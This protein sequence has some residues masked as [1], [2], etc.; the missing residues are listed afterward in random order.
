VNSPDAPI[1]IIGAG[2]VGLV[3]AVGMTEAGHQVELVEADPDR[4]ATLRTG[5]IP[6]F[7]AGLP[8]AFEQAVGS[9]SL[10][11]LDR[12]NEG[13][14]ITLVCVGTPISDDGRSDLSQLRAALA[15]VDQVAGPRTVLVLRSTLPVGG[16][17]RIQEWTTVPT[18]RI[19][20]NPEFLRQ[21]SALSDFRKPARVVVGRFDDAD[22][23]ALAEVLALFKVE[24]VETL[25]VDVTASELIKNGANAFLALKLSFANELAALAEEV[26]TDVGDVLAGIT[27]DPRIGSSY[28][29]PGFGFGGSCL[30]KELQTLAVAG[31]SVGLDMHVTTAASMANLAQQ[32]RF[33]TRVATLLGGLNGKRIGLLGLAFKSGTDD[34]RS[35]PALRLAAALLASGADVRAFDPAAAANARRVMPDLIT[36]EDPTAVFVDADA[37]VVAT[38]WPEFR[39]LPFVDLRDLM[40]QPLLI[41]G[42]RLI[43]AEAL[44]ALGYRVAVVGSGTRDVDAV[45]INAEAPDLRA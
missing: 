45:T 31:R 15:D 21:G 26:G 8:E 40:A 25:V 43:D 44:R 30:P 9:G 14:G 13:P 7:E 24:G 12:P 33:A 37:V 32:D 6:I 19:F 29:K 3:T 11:V 2:Y 28:L 34:V 23:A 36:V 5:H 10:R 17:A 1:T 41:D 42:R 27:S 38:E 22:Q 18:A 4:V 20:T 39:E 35:S 16:A